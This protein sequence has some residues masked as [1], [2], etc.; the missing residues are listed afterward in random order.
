M[1]VPG[2]RIRTP[3]TGDAAVDGRIVRR[4]NGYFEVSATSGGD[5]ARLDVAEAGRLEVYAGRDRVRGGLTGISVALPA[6]IAG[7]MICAKRCARTERGARVIAP[8]Q[9]ALAGTA[10]GAGLGFILAPER[11]RLV[12]M[13]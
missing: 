2:T 9:G 7:G 13:R 1:L 11:W 3:A 6:G 5:L 10:V 12:L 8:A 4:V